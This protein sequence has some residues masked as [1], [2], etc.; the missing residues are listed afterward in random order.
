MP[1][2]NRPVTETSNQLTSDIDVAE[3][4]EIVRLLRSTDAQIFGG[5]GGQVGL[6]DLD[7]IE[8][9]AKLADM[10]A[11]ILAQ[12]AGRVILS[13]AGT[14]GRLAMCAA[15]TFNRFFGTKKNPEPFRYTI[16][17]TDLALIAAQEGAEDD[18]HT[19]A[20]NLAKA[21]EGASHVFYVGITCGLSAPYVAG[22]IDSFLKN[23]VSGYAVLLGFNPEEF[24]RDAKVEGW[25]STFKQVLERAQ[26]AENFMLLNPVVGPEPVTGSTRM[27]SG[28]ATKVILE[29]LFCAANAVNE[30]DDA[31]PEERLIALA[32][33]VRVLFN[34]YESAI[35]EAYLPSHEMARVIDLAG[36][37]L[38]TGGRIFYLG[39]TSPLIISGGC[40]HDHDDDDGH[41][42]DHMPDAR[43]YSDGGVL[44]L[45]DASECPPTY[46]ARF[47]DVRG[48]LEGGWDGL[49]GGGKD[50]S[51]HGPHYRISIDDFRKD[52][53]PTLTKKDL[54]IFLGNFEG[55]DDLVEAIHGKE[56]Q[57]AAIFIP[58]AGTPP[59]VWNEIAVAPPLT[60]LTFEVD[61]EPTLFAGPPQLTIK[62]ILNAI[63]TG[64]YILNG[65]VF[66]NRMI[67][68]R[69]SNNKLF[70]RAIGIISDLMGVSEDVAHSALIKSIYQ[71]D[72]ITEAM[73]GASVRDHIEASKSVPKLVPIALLLATGKYNWKQATDAL[74]DEPI[75]RNIISK[76]VK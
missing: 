44:G 45:I 4:L 70:Y 43:L 37:A 62:L 30:G 72:T 67:D 32:Y 21:A 58:Q 14:S 64:G 17:G 38:N 35:R 39:N 22:Q 13:G 8:Q 48:Y 61:G 36:Q 3:A 51:E 7:F 63:T 6:S 54:V 74:A 25:D 65:K 29:T 18:P 19:G 71:T 26:K 41:D 2:A 20:A 56:T 75:V 15:R 46:G 42:H 76:H 66:G 53:L 73:E 57:T 52:A 68:L 11:Y 24:A 16:A 12:P 33:V 69:I 55:R 49:L 5:Y 27:K 59:A 10:A 50:Y 9:M 1:V 60:S 40:G 31:D 23:E 47:E 28:S 34:E